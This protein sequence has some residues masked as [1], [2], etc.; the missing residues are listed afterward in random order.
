MSEGTGNPPGIRILVVDDNPAIHRDFSK[1]LGNRADPAVEL[2]AA[3]SLLFGEPARKE[4]ES[5]CYA[6]EFASQGEAGIDCARRALAAGRAFAIAFID[7]RM[8]P[9]W[10]GLE[11]IERL[12]RVDPDIQVVICSAHSDYDWNDVI[13]RLGETDRQIGRAHV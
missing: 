6:L 5:V 11:T 4:R 8:P 10:D 13:N 7:M 9:G 12:W 1:I 3:E 2:T